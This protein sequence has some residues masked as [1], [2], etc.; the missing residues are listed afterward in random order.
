MLTNSLRQATRCLNL[1]S[2]A[3]CNQQPSGPKHLFATSRY[4]HSVIPTRQ[5]G[6]KYPPSLA[7]A[8]LNSGYAASLKRKRGL[9][10]YVGP[11]TAVL[12]LS[13]ANR[14]CGLRPQR[15]D[16]PVH[17][18]SFRLCHRVG[19]SFGYDCPRAGRIANTGY[20]GGRLSCRGGHKS[21]GYVG[22]GHKAVS[23][24]EGIR[25]GRSGFPVVG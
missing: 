13:R 2:A 7:L 1:R 10:T 12:V 19:C 20:G 14:R 6:V 9:L 3:L 22:V 15:P 4:R 5:I 17:L 25:S 18:S 8:K 16:S 11:Q 21:C 23:G 24:C